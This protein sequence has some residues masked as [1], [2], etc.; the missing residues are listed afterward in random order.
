M[1]INSYSTKSIGKISFAI[2][3]A[4]LFLGT[5]QSAH[6]AGVSPGTVV[7][8]RVPAGAEVT[9]TVVFSR[10]NPSKPAVLEIEFDG[11]AKEALTGPLKLDIP[12]GQRVVEYELT[13]KP[14]S[15]PAG[16]Y[17]A[18]VTGYFTMEP[19]AN[20]GGAQQAIR[21][22]A[23]ATVLFEIT[24]ESIEEF[25]IDAVTVP[26]TEEGQSVVVTYDIVNKGNV[27]TKPDRIEFTIFDRIN[28]EMD[29]EQTITAEALPFTKAF[30]RE[31]VTLK[32]DA[33]LDEGLYLVDTFIYK[34]DEL[35]F[36]RLGYALQVFP[37]GTLA[38]EGIFQEFWTDKA[39]YAV[40]EPIQFG[41]IFKNSGDVGVKA[42]MFIDVMKDGQRLDILTSDEL[43]VPPNQVAE[44]EL[45]TKL[46]EGGP[47]EFKARVK[48]G[49]SKTGP[50]TIQVNVLVASDTTVMV[51]LGI[52]VLVIILLVWLFMRK[53]APKNQPPTNAGQTQHTASPTPPPSA[54][55]VAPAGQ[56]PPA[57]PSQTQQVSKVDP[58]SDTPVGTG[59]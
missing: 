42:T 51:V 12:I 31:Q 55:P 29:H 33:D 8:E 3:I 9:K 53:K 34:N 35:V 26:S 25:I 14:G 47:Y 41:G 15:M 7:F 59:T 11:Q 36:E 40:G 24:N 4:L 13:L 10:L 54:P 22:G 48:Y 1:F 18:G 30:K 37:E 6:A 57:Q 46:L 45:N 21:L 43:V 19:D 56:A 52:I 16:E 39:E 38:Q 5:V 17:E 44:F 28:Q 49:I 58:T 32:L 50:L 23:R 20:A 27:D 2:G